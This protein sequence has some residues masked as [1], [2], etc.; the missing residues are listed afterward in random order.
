MPFY[1][2]LFRIFNNNNLKI[3]W[4]ES[5]LGQVFNL[6]CFVDVLLASSSQDPQC[7]LWQLAVKGG[8]ADM[9]IGTLQIVEWVKGKK[10][11]GPFEEGSTKVAF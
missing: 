3:S 4:R 9:T 7:A 10:N 5:G 1:V 6:C 8:E 2:V 11:L